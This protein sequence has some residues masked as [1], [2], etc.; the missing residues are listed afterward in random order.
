MCDRL[1]KS[2]VIDNRDDYR[3]LQEEIEK[4]YYNEIEAK[5]HLEKDYHYAQKFNH[6]FKCH[7]FNDMINLSYINNIEVCPL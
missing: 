4:E 6:N 2:L 5:S 3:K 7:S 1:F